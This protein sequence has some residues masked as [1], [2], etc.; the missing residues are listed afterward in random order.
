MT[1]IRLEKINDDNFYEVTKLRLKR[2]QKHFVAENTYSLVH[3]YLALINGQQAFPF[4]VYADDI[5]V[6]FLMVGYDIF[7]NKKIEKRF[8][9]FLRDSYV[10]WRLMIDKRYQNKGY[11][12]RAVELALEFIKTLPCGEAEYCWLSYE[13]ENVAAKN[14]YATFGFKEIPEAYRE[15]GEMPA[16]LRIKNEE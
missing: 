1:Q 14:L 6:G 15:G 9:W 12:K 8:D 7:R 3:A 5:I 2:E 4:A 11:G 16:V 10:L 13:K